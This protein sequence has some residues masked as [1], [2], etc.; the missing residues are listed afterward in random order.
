MGRY[1]NCDKIEVYL[2]FAEAKTR[3][4]DLINDPKIERVVMQRS[5][6]LFEMNAYEVKIWEKKPSFFSG[7]F[8]ME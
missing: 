2:T 6:D 4:K 1:D 8:K 5:I 3:V 7:L